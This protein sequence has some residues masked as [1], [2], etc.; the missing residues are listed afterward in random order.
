MSETISVDFCVIGGGGA[1]IEVAIA[2][3]AFGQRVAVI[4]KHKTGGDSLYCGG[5]A[6]K[7]LLAAGKRAQAMR[8]AGKF[9]IA[10]VEPRID[11]RAVRDGVRGVIDAIAPNSAIERLSG[12]GIRVITAAGRFL[13]KQT[14]AAGEHRV[15]AR[16]F[17]IATGSSPLAPPI[18]GLADI[19]YFTNETI[20]DNARFL[21]HLI[22]IGATGVGLELAQAHRRLGSAVT[23]LESANVLAEYDPELAQ[24]LLERLN[25]E[26]VDIR[27]GVRIE[28]VVADAA[29]V[30]IALAGG[31]EIEGS[32]ILVAAGRKPNI[33]DLGLEAAGVKFDASG[34]KVSGGLIT[35]N[36]RVFAVGDATGDPPFTHNATE[37]AGVVIKRALFKL[38]VN[39]A[40]HASPRVVF[41]DPELAHV[42]L[43]EQDARQKY[44]R[45]SALRWP[46]HENDRAQAERETSGHAKVVV[47]KRGR[48]RGATIAGAQAG[49]LIQMWSLAVAHGMKINAMT[50]WIS[51][52]PT[53]SEINKRAA[54]RHLV[55]IPSKPLVRKV[56]ALLSKL[57]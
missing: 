2:A 47:D 35:S 55:T 11:H 44:G 48:I 27:D 32:H 39:V 15:T 18:P 10:P 29:G 56:I 3:A 36:A 51:A 8:E 19:P 7:A 46:Y 1:G 57:G 34:V 17:V 23:V 45:V 4:E 12:L 24:P 13:D 53:L 22:V 38:P 33:S 14:V 49:E 50:R 26:G 21:P 40:K 28:R 31:G 54:F 20:F 16:Y 43:A 5:A 37:H 25:A 41:T 6:S 30:R 52:Y 42:G 9:G